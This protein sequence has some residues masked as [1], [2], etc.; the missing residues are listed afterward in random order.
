MSP[1]LRH[2]SAC[3][4]LVTVGTDHHPFDRLVNW[5]NSWLAAR[6]E[7]DAECYLQSGTTTVPLGCPGASFLTLEE[8]TRRL[9]EADVIVCHGGPGSI[10]AAWKRG[11]LPIVVPRLSALGEHVDDHQADFCQQI[12]GAGQIA[13]AQTAEDFG[14]L[15]DK[16]VAD[17]ATFSISLTSTADTAVA[18]VGALIEEL[19]ARPRRRGGLIW[20]RSRRRAASESKAGQAGAAGQVATADDAPQAV[21]NRG[22]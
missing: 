12:A 3:R 14:L 8:L 2:G 11:R 1:S 15:L 7:P 4:V 9:D 22:S 5:T 18:R 6:L 16:A 17:P 19:V 13:L 20:T 21:T 10:S